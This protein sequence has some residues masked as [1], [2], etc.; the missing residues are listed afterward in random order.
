MLVHTALHHFNV[1][2][3][4]AAETVS[5]LSVNY[6]AADALGVNSYPGN[7]STHRPDKEVRI[8]GL[9]LP[10]TLNPTESFTHKSYST[11]GAG[12]TDLARVSGQC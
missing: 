8:N 1:S 2:V 4:F 3:K 10:W 9:R 6:G 11:A 5:C 7:N 12:L